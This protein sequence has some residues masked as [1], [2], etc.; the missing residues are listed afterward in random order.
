MLT[1]AMEYFGIIKDFRQAGYYETEP[2][3]RLFKDIKNSVINGKL[4]VISGIVG[5]GK[6]AT[7]RHLFEMLE[8]D[9]KVIVS[10]SW[11]VDKKRTNLSTLISALFYDLSKEKKITIPSQTEIRERELCSLLRKVKKPV[12]LFVDEAHDLLYSTLTGLKRL[13]EL[14]EDSGSLLSLVLA[15]HPK[16]KN[17][18]RRPTM[19]E[20]G[21]RATIFTLDGISN[22]QKEYIQ[23]L[24]T[25][26]VASGTD[27]N[28]ILS[29]SALDI[30]SSRLK[31]PL[32]IQQHLSVAIEDAYKL[33]DKTITPAL[34]EDIL[35]KHIDDLEPNLKRHGY[36]VLDLAE[37]FNAKPAEIKSMFRGQLDPARTK[38]LHDQMLSAGLPLLNVS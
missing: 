38:E 30:L 16:L 7:L 27:I 35:S 37:Q 15:G 8:S 11:S 20:I 17:N 26:C 34:I 29:A 13:I 6:T 31:T 2:H 18:L 23:W 36:S 4:I 12:A 14:A 19:E 3:Q 21:S 32:Q 28:N 25:Q 1:E 33:G 9:G 10:K 5:S 24:L 22:H